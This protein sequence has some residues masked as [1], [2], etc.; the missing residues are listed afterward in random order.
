[1]SCGVGRR[2]GSDSVL[3][4]LWCRQAAVALIRPLAWEPSY[5]VGVGLEKKKKGFYLKVMWIILGA[6]SGLLGW[7]LCVVLLRWVIC[8]PVKWKRFW[9]RVIKGGV[10]APPLSAVLLSLPFPSCVP[11]WRI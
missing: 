10:T 6:I 2:R 5:A 11:L 9:S 7:A 4:W 1:M 3:L 8:V